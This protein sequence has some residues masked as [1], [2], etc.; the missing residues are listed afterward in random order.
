MNPKSISARTVQLALGSAIAILL[1][2]GAF[3]YRGMGVSR[4]S[5]RWV[6]HTHEVL[7]NLQQ[8]LLAM[9]S[10]ESSSRGFV[11]IGDESYLE[12]YRASIASLWQHEATV[13]DLTADNPNQQR[14]LPVLEQLAAQTIQFAEVVND[15][16]R[17]KGLETAADE[18]RSGR[19]GETMKGFA[20]VVRQMQDEELRLLVQ[21]DADVTSRLRSTRAVLILASVLGM[22]TSAAAGWTLWSGSS[23]GLVAEEALRH[24]EDKYRTLI[25]GIRDHAILMLGPRGEIFSWNPGAERMTGCAHDDIAGHH[26]SSFF[27]REDIKRGRLDEILRLADAN[28]LHEEQGT[29]VRKDGSRFMARSTFTALR[30]RS[31]ALHGFSVISLDLSESIESGAKYRGL[32]EAAPDAMVVVN[33]GGEIALLNLQAE[34][35]FGYRRDELLGQPVKNIIPEGFAERLI[36]DRL[37]SAEDALAQQIGAGIELT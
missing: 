10:I 23:R 32:L 25:Q 13:R 4:E 30:D 22:L 20:A 21:R 5:D 8:M 28:G 11:L 3:S 16:R 1:V 26:F 15:L 2:V 36:A 12:S 17:A 35:Q 33:Q 19:G 9:S 37:R 27:P 6:R 34:K 24:S 14:E 29:L 18:V 7:A 31:G